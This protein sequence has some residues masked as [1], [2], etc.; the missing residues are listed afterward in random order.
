MILLNCIYLMRLELF[1]FAVGLMLILNAVLCLHALVRKISR[2]TIIGLCT[3][4]VIISVRYARISFCFKCMI[5]THFLRHNVF[6]HLLNDI[7]FSRSV[8]YLLYRIVVGTPTSNISANVKCNDNC[9]ARTLHCNHVHW[10]ISYKRAICCGLF[11]DS[12]IRVTR[13]VWCH[14]I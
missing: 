3:L 4:Y 11:F 12:A 9:A 13:N 8:W 6:C 7:S 14:A 2:S 5:G 10:F 1:T